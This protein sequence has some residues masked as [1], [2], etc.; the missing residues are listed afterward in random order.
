MNINAKL[1]YI[2]CYFKIKEDWNLRD[3]ADFAKQT[4]D[5]LLRKKPHDYT[6]HFYHAKWLLRERML[7]DAL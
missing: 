1:N 7:D 6:T 5:I 4:L 2:R 3:L